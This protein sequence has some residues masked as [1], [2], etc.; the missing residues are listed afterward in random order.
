VSCTILDA[1]QV[2]TN[3]GLV[4]ALRDEPDTGTCGDEVCLNG[5][6]VNSVIPTQLG[7]GAVGH[8]FIFFDRS[9]TTDVFGPPCTTKP[10]I[11]CYTYEIF[12]KLPTGQSQLIGTSLT[13]SWCTNGV[14]P[15]GKKGCLK[16]L[17]EMN[18]KTRNNP[19][20]LD[21]IRADVFYKG[22]P[23]IGGSG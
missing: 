18:V 17:I 21:D 20:D 6:Q 15:T 2:G 19:N 7:T 8:S 5:Q 14:I 22:D 12:I 4:L 1:T 10:K 16:Q 9:I 13:S 3:G 11:G 23:P